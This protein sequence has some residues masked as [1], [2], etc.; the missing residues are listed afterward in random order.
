MTEMAGSAA[1]MKAE[2]EFIAAL[3]AT[4]GFVFES[5]WLVLVDENG[6]HLLHFG[7]V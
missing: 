4:A 3:R 6:R 2:D 7:R 1:D 5:D